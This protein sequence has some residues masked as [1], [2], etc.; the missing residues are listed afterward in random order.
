MSISQ[1]LA[2]MSTSLMSSWWTIRILLQEK[3]DLAD[4]A[5]LAIWLRAI[6]MA[7]CGFLKKSIENLAQRRFLGEMVQLVLRG[8][9]Y[10]SPNTYQ[11]IKVI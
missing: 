9:R 10:D 11:K 7:K 3:D 5:N 6:S 1:A 8:L 4:L 2:L